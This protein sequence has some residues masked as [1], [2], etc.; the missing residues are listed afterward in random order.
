MC[1]ANL[2]IYYNNNGATDREIR[3]DKTQKILLYRVEIV[4]VSEDRKL[5]VL[6]QGCSLQINYNL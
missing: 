5:R 4:R 1:S 6:Y 3:D 2:F